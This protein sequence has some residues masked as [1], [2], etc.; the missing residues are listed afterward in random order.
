ML[1]KEAVQI[2]MAAGIR[3]AIVIEFVAH[4]PSLEE[5]PSR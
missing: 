4:H 2:A 5:W 1:R 3:T